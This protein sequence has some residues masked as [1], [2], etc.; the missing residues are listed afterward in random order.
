F[1]PTTRYKRVLNA[2]RLN[3]KFSMHNFAILLV[4]CPDRKGVVASIAEFIFRHHGNILFNDEHGDEESNLL[5]TRVE[6][7]PAD[8]DFDLAQFSERFAPIARDFQ[9]DWRLAHSADRPRIA[10]FVSKFD[11]CLQDLL[12]RHQS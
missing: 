9:M 2:N 11:H 6:F 10:I 1:D 3:R 5:L 8:F 7:D 12:Y 4:S